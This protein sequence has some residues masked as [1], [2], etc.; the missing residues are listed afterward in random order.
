LGVWSPLSLI[1]PLDGGEL[2]RGCNLV[3]RGD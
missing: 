3:G 2:K 1:L